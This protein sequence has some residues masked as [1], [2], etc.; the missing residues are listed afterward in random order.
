MKYLLVIPSCLFS[1]SDLPLITSSYFFILSSHF[2][3]STPLV[4]PLPLLPPTRSYPQS[5]SV[6]AMDF[7]KDSCE[8]R[9]IF[10]K[11]PLYFVV[12]D[13]KVRSP[14]PHTS[15]ITSTTWGLVLYLHYTALRCITLHCTALYYTVL[16]YT[17]IALH[18]T[19]LYYTA[20]HCTVL[21]CT[22]LHCIALHCTALY[23]TALYCTALH[24]SVLHLYYTALHC[25]TPVLYC[26]ALHHTALY[27]IVSYS[28][29]L[30][31]I[32]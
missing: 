19:A 15:M 20:L 6:A 27:C 13:L 30:C 31:R 12:A 1:S 11:A 10:C 32:S 18:C 28:Y 8:L 7:D 5:G 24:C 4:S 2:S 21:Y 3:L 23:C 25:T 16:Y 29:L 22:V 14:L 17:C 9:T 26:T